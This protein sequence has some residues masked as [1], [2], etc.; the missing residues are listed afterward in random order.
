MAEDGGTEELGED[1]GMLPHDDPAE[2]TRRSSA[3]QSNGLG[4]GAS[5]GNVD[6][7]HS[8]SPRRIPLFERASA[9]WWNPQFASPILETQYW[10]CSFPILRD[11]FRSGLVY[12]A[13]TCLS[14]MIYLKVFDFDQ[15]SH[16]VTASI[17]VILCF[18]MFRFTQFAAHYQRFYLPTSFLCTFSIC[19]ITLLIF[20]GNDSFMGPVA[21]I[22]TSIQVILLIYTVIPL[23]LYL[24]IGI[25]GV[26]TLI[27]ELLTTNSGDPTI[28]N[29]KI[30]DVSSAYPGTK[31]V[32]H[33][34]VHLLGVHLYILTQVRQR[35]TFLKVGQSLLARKDLELE[36]Q[37]K[38]HMIQ[39]VMPKKVADELLQE[40]TTRNSNAS[41]NQNGPN[42]PRN[43]NQLQAG[44]S[45]S[46]NQKTMN[47]EQ[48]FSG[49]SAQI[50]VPNVRKF[51][52]FTMNLMQDVSILFADIAG[53]TKM[54][55]NKTA[56]ELVNLL[57]DLFGRFDYLCGRCGLEK[58]STLGDCYYC[59][60]GCPEPV[61]DHAK[62]CVEMGLAMII[63]IRQF[64]MDRG[65]EVNMRVGIHTGKVM[66]GMVGTKRF[67]FDVFSN[68]V[69]LANEMESTG[70]AGRVHI[71]EITAQY[72]DNQY[73]LEPGEDH[74]GIKTYFIAGRSKEFESV[75]NRLALSDSESRSEP[76][77]DG[78][79][80]SAKLVDR[81]RTADS[82][83]LPISRATTNSTCGGSLRMRL[84]DRSSSHRMASNS[85][86]LPARAISVQQD[87]PSSADLNISGDLTDS[88]TNLKSQSMCTI[89]NP[90]LQLAPKDIS[91][92]MMG[93]ADNDAANSIPSAPIKPEES[94]DRKASTAPCSAR[95]NW[96]DAEKI[97]GQIS[98]ELAQN[99]STNNSAKGSRSSGLHELASETHSVGGL[100]TA[101]SHHHN[102][103][104]LTRFDTDNRD[105]DQ[106]LAQILQ[107]GESSFAQGFWMHQDSLNRWTLTF[108]EADIED[109]YR[110]HFAESGDHNSQ[111]VA[112]RAFK[113]PI[114]KHQQLKKKRNLDDEDEETGI[115]STA[116]SMEQQLLKHPRY[117]YS[118][119]FIDILVAIGFW[120]IVVGIAFATLRQLTIPFLA[121]VACSALFFL[122]F[123][124]IVALPLI[125]RKKIS[126]WLNRWGPRHFFGLLMILM[127][128]GAA[129]FNMPDCAVDLDDPVTADLHRLGLCATQ[130]ILDQRL[131]FC[132]MT[133]IIIY[134]HCN[135]SQLRAWP[136]SGQ[137]IIVALLFLASNLLCQVEI[138]TQIKDEKFTNEPNCTKV[139]NTWASSDFA[140][141]FFVYELIVDVALAV[142]LVAFLNYQFEASFRM[143]FF[144]DV[145]ARRDTAKM[146]VVRDQADWL[147]TNIIPQHAVESLKTNTKYS[148]NHQ[149]T[150]V[151]FASITNWN[152]MYEENFEGGREFL[153]VLNEVIGDFDELLDRPEFCHVE[154]IK[155][156][157]STYMAASG[158]NPD[159]R[160]LALHPYEHI[161]QLIEFAVALQNALDY[162]NQDLLNFDFVCKIGINIGPVTAGVIGT[163]KLY[164]DIWGDTVN[165]ASRMYS[166][167]VEDRIQVSEETKKLLVDRY[168]FEYRAHIDVKGVDGGMDTYLLVGRK[169]EPPIN[170]PNAIKPSSF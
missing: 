113:N 170:G 98:I 120:S 131:V 77:V 126:V 130:V 30:T 137:A 153:R 147:L 59:V 97:G 19:V 150:A 7:R 114:A 125:T 68:D 37:F 103:G 51:R 143:S 106:R 41:N 110:K 121:F 91:D 48:R 73:I 54:S 168:D 3:N 56:D 138:S 116:D 85:T 122:A 87:T 92:S 105:F 94:D 162:F 79:K 161:Y 22:A 165:I 52:P 31:L 67:K 1:A 158:L 142:I 16:W 145:Q 75:S 47:T 136:K 18:T 58:I 144:G 46:L 127:P 43:S 12:I 82:A 39:S 123:I 13:M 10:K 89:T 29:G 96:S 86:N 93:L 40:S 134:A 118:G 156:I 148:E 115:R 133:L 90:N 141:P 101:I 35:K 128:L 33:I 129:V 17:I 27:F 81:K 11:R 111:A 99:S 152:E 83:S 4:N 135:F 76:I 95:E 14:W 167:G 119:V 44:N 24:C 25:C 140:A 109:E 63:A 69:T 149:M 61:S 84:L 50:S 117:R 66:C 151:L 55:S 102:A 32:L 42:Q 26:Y 88:T 74:K 78:Q 139:Y 164:Y 2:P 132:Y 107:G 38:D 62:C 65:Q 159:R 70:I 53:F 21:R 15:L 34:C 36:T 112:Q 5:G 100:D 20:S 9:R 64:D 80:I 108:N 104:S 160:R 49:D 57:N 157:G 23:P 28:A 154:K 124:I 169:G 146:R 71:S 155:T 166:T 8:A 45:P 163:T 60:A 72:L 6:S